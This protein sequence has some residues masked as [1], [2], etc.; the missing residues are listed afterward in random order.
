MNI[1]P[2]LGSIQFGDMIVNFTDYQSS[3]ERA[4]IVLL[5]GT[6]GSAQRHFGFL[7]PML[8]A[9]QRVIAIDFSHPGNGERA[10]EVEDLTAQASAVLRH[11]LPGTPAVVCGYSLGAVVAVDLAA[12]TPELVERLILV[13][14]WMKSD[15]QQQLRNRVWN[16]LRTET[17][18]ALCGY[19]TY[20]GYS[21][22]YLAK[23]TPADLEVI[24]SRIDF[25]EFLDAQMDLNRRIDVTSAAASVIAPTLVVG[26]TFDQ[27]APVQHS[28]LLL[29]AIE[30]ARYAEIAAG[31]AV[32]IERPAELYRLIDRFAAER[33]V[34][35]A[36]PVQIHAATA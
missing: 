36:G 31:H 12:G 11:L 9:H 26:C 5:H 29:G 3:S 1:G 19:M 14:G 24:M 20:C 34:G 33:R 7:M 16:T 13:N 35:S 27:M 23:I 21:Q 8:A 30:D 10:L 2:T 15:N 28:K 25:T 32:V 17:S 4:P 6:G 18:E 22:Q